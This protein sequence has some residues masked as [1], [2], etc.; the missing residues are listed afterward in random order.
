MVELGLTGMPRARQHHRRSEQQWRTQNNAKIHSLRVFLAT[1]PHRKRLSFGEW[2]IWKRVWPG[3]SKN[4]I[5]SV[6]DW[7]SSMLR[8]VINC[9]ASSAR[10]PLGLFPFAASGAPRANRSPGGAS[11]FPKALQQKPGVGVFVGLNGGTR[12][13]PFDYAWSWSAKSGSPPKNAIDVAANTKYGNLLVNLDTGENAASVSARAAVGIFFRLPLWSLANFR[14]WTNPT[15][16]FSWQ[17]YCGFAS[18][19]TDGFVGLFAAS[20][21]WAG[22]FRAT[23][24][25][26][27]IS[28]WSDDS[29]WSGTSGSG[30]STFPLSANFLVDSD[31]VGLVRKP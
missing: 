2:P 14:F 1:M 18:V 31:V 12:V 19:H 11:P 26:Q 23:L 16:G 4:L 27:M 6:H 7:L 29:W 3:A 17:E 30:E 24:V 13:V 28:L 9:W 10:I 8:S 5:S 25:D 22:N 20:Y 15:V 21:D